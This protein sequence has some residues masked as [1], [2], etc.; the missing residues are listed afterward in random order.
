MA[1]IAFAIQRNL[2]DMSISYYGGNYY[3]GNT[4]TDSKRQFDKGDH[5]ETTE[6][7]TVYVTDHYNIVIP[8]GTRGYISDSEW[9]SLSYPVR[10]KF[11]DHSIEVWLTNLKKIEP[12]KMNRKEFAGGE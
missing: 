9:A 8:A 2:E 7:Q 1:N 5:V 4:S 3:G 11:I 10:V 6:E 12:K